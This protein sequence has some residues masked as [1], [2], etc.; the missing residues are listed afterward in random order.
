MAT[1][2]KA[3]LVDLEKDLTC[4]ICTEVLYQP[5]TLIDCLHSFCGACL[6]EWFSLQARHARVANPYTC[7]SCR[8]SVLG[9]KPNA[10]V[11]SILEDYLRANPTRQKSDEEKAEVAKNYTPGEAILRPIPSRRIKRD[12]DDLL[13][14]EVRQ[15]SLLP[16]HTPRAQERRSG[17]TRRER[18]RE[19]RDRHDGQRRRAEQ[20]RSRHS[21]DD[22]T[23]PQ[24][25]HAR[26]RPQ[27][28]HQQQQAPTVLTRGIEHQS[29]L[30]SLLSASDIDTA[31]LEEEIARLIVDEGLLDGIDFSEVGAAQ[32]E[33]IRERI[34]EAYRRRNRDRAGSTGPVR[35]SSDGDRNSRRAR[36]GGR[37]QRTHSRSHSASMQNGPPGPIQS[38]VQGES[39][40]PRTDNRRRTSNRSPRSTSPPARGHTSRHSSGQVRD[41]AASATDLSEAPSPSR[42]SQSRPANVESEGRRRTDPESGI[43]SRRHHEDEQ[44]SAHADRHQEASATR[45]QINRPDEPTRP[46]DLE[47]SDTT[48]NE[49]PRRSHDESLREPI[50]RPGPS[51]EQGTPGTT[52]EQHSSM[53]LASAGRT[54]TLLYPEPFISCARCEKPDIQYDLHYN[55]SQCDNGEFNLCLPCYRQGR[56]CRHWYG[57]GSAAWAKYERQ[58][59]AGGYPPNHPLPH[60]LTGHRFLRP[61]QRLLQAVSTDSSRRPRSTED[62]L[63]RLQTGVFCAMCSSFAN[64]CYW[65]CDVCND[66]EWGFCNACVVTG[67]CCSHALLPLAYIP[68][69][70]TL[71]AGEAAAGAG[72]T[73][74][75]PGP[76][77]AT[78][79]R[80][81]WVIEHGPL[82]PLSI[83]TSCNICRLPIQPSSTRYHCLHC[84]EGNYD[85]CTPC[86]LKLCSNGRIS[87]EHGNKG[88]RRCLRGHRMIVVGFEDQDGGRKRI[89]VRD[90]VGGLALKDE[91]DESTGVDG[92]RS[93]KAVSGGSGSGN[94]NGTGTGKW[95]WSEGPDGHREWKFV[96]QTPINT[97]HRGSNLPEISSKV[98]TISSSSISSPLHFPPDG[99]VGMRVLARWGYFP[100]DDV[101]DELM[102]PRNAEI[103]EVE[104]INGDWYWGC[105]AGRKGLFPGP[106]VQVLDVV[107]A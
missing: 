106:Y 88:W 32:E 71:R 15:A 12:D 89:V 66:G 103:R 60:T 40:S 33:A 54:R 72:T 75:T 3:N 2:Q 45:S 7:P 65:K 84:N 19:T 91:L 23:P 55:C 46:A 27:Q 105:Y 73:I 85:I 52:N 82:K 47:A 42:P 77:G 81:P 25:G 4:S 86:Y 16:G 20:D 96:S 41:P 17:N 69:H 30:R 43:A 24:A 57:F 29:S 74:T 26:R 61:T 95:S 99:G 35:R 59:P 1:D 34:D 13:L 70:D 93:S 48:S 68:S 53:G 87:P 63:K 94:G 11:T 8:A 38:I 22:R 58:T 98:D 79:L 92:R 49:P 107:G 67:Q 64:S 10:L 104:D 80:E 100:K 31:D 44:H 90:L 76:P 83:S 50:T 14:A 56:G 9:T 18:S 37:R 97:N 78:L 101:T 21:G 6:K 5:L 62:P 36:E 28:Q 39:S 51:T 102:F